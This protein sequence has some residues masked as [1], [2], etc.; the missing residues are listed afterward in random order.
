MSGSE[1]RSESRASLVCLAFSV[2]DNHP[3]RAAPAAVAAGW[4]VSLHPRCAREVAEESLSLGS[5][6]GLW[7]GGLLELG[8]LSEVP[9]AP[10]LL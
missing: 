8:W 6:P 1:R 10:G 9:I 3:P 2:L 4:E 5:F 7:E